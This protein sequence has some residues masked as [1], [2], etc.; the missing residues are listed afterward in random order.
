[1]FCVRHLYKRENKKK[2][3]SICTM[4]RSFKNTSIGMCGRVLT[5]SSSSNVCFVKNA[6]LITRSLTLLSRFTPDEF[7]MDNISWL[8]EYEIYSW[9][10]PSSPESCATAVVSSKRIVRSSW[11][12]FMPTMFTRSNDWSRRFVS[13][14]EIELK[15]QIKSI[16]KPLRSHP[17]L[18]RMY[19]VSF[20]LVPRLSNFW[21][22]HL[23]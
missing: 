9:S 5:F 15:E 8:I 3:L 2:I 21:H 17:H 18:I 1:M 7:P 19:Q 23:H 10:K 6:Y 22:L 20:H 14:W 4:T 12:L 13:W 11:S 16:V